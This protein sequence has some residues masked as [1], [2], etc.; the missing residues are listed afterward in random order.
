VTGRYSA[1]ASAS[2]LSASS[3]V[4]ILVS[5]LS[6][7]CGWVVRIFVCEAL[8]CLGL[9]QWEEAADFP[10]EPLIRKCTGD[11]LWER[12]RDWAKLAQI[13]DRVSQGGGVNRQPCGSRCPQRESSRPAKRL[14]PGDRTSVRGEDHVERG[15]RE[16]RAWEERLRSISIESRS[17]SRYNQAHERERKNRRLWRVKPFFKNTVLWSHYSSIFVKFTLEDSQ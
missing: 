8:I 16:P 6:G 11:L 12:E 10:P 1:N 2:A 13:W 4:P 7:C 15:Q 3:V 17:K 5:R 14:T 9:L